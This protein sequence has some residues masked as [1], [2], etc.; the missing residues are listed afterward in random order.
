MTRRLPAGDRAAAVTLA[1]E[2]IATGAGREAAVR[3]TAGELGVSPETLR[4]WMRRAGAAEADGSNAAAALA[5]RLRPGRPPRIWSEPGAGEAWRVW[6]AAYLRLE[7]PTAASCYE[8]VRQMAA[9][10]DWTVPSSAAFLRRL[11]AEVP[12]R[13]VVRAREGRLAV[14]STIPFQER[15]VEGMLPLDY[16]NGDGYNHC[17]FVVPPGGG[18]PVRPVTW[19]WQDIRSRRTLAWWSGLTESADVLRRAFYELVTRHGVPRVVVLDNTRA[20]SAKWFGGSSRRWRVDKEDVPSILSRL[21][22]IPVRTGVEKTAGGKGAGRAWAKPVERAFLD[23]DAIDKHPLAAGAYTGRN[24]DTKP[25]NYQGR[26]L[27]WAEF[28]AVRDDGIR[29][30]NA[31]PGRRTEAAAGRSFDATWAAEIATT[32]VRHLTRAQEAL[33]LAAAESTRVGRD[34]TFRLAAGKGSGLP[35]NRY[36][37]EALMA[38]AGKKVVARYDADDLHAGVEVFSLDGRWL[39]RAEC[40]APTGFGD[41]AAAGEYNRARRRIQ[42]D[43]DRAHAGREKLADLLEEH[44]VV[45]PPAPAPARPTLVRMVPHKEKRPDATRRRALEERLG[46]GLRRISGQ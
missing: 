37:D 22:I 36:H 38:H 42:R 17:L 8:L 3:L 12:A 5:D 26:A 1:T 46:R 24:P 14:L 28:L 33:L 40:I 44:R 11:R 10:R 18:D 9:T 30:L 23:W 21:G 34:G 41:M 15:T 29:T 13:E 16:V 19:A 32:P 25:E 45:L 31:R 27:A 4:R 7:A 39:C 43:L 2:R 6:R 20:A 35:A